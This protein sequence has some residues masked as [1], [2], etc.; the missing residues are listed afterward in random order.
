M[1]GSKHSSLPWQMGTISAL[2][3]IYAPEAIPSGCDVTPKSN[4]VQ[5]IFDDSLHATVPRYLIF[6]Y[7]SDSGMFP[8]SNDGT[9]TVSRLSDIRAQDNARTIWR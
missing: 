1:T 3:V 2:G 7:R 6:S 4:F 9:V 8:T 5:H